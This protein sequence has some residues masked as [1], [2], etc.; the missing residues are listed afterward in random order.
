MKIFI[1]L[2]LL[3]ISSLSAFAQ[4]NTQQPATTTT[5]VRPDAEERFKK[6]V[7]NAIGPTAFIGPAFS[8]TFK[9]IRNQP[10]EWGKTSKGFAKRFGDSVGRNV[11][12]QTI[13]Y[14]LDETLKLD[15]NYYRSSK[16][17]FKSKFSNAV[18]SAFTARNK[19]GKRVV[20]VPILV[21]TYSSAIIANE[22]WMPNRFNYKN[23]LR[24][25]SISIV[26]KIGFN[27]LKEFVF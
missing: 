18:V 14:G 13:T 25:G 16:K 17:E 10:E 21:G 15:S 3:F 12:K 4:T 20:G 24:D 26:T 7:N 8:S 2:G 19:N 1:I 23:G 27:L 11:I 5:Y 9:Q 6:Y 22:T